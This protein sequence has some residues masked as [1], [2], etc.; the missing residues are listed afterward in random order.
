MLAIRPMTLSDWLKSKRIKRYQFAHRIDVRP[1]VVTEY[2]KGTIRP[3]PEKM[4]AIVRE[5]AGE[6]TADDFLSQEAQT[7]IASAEAAA[8]GV[9]R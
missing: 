5:T 1:S 6:V 2:C 4:E 3:R 7:L 9:G 8:A